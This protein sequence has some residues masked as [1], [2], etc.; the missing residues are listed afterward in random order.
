MKRRVML[1]LLWAACGASTAQLG[2]PGEGAAGAPQIQGDEAK[3]SGE[4]GKTTDDA[5]AATRGTSGDRQRAAASLD[6]L[7]ARLLE[8]KEITFGGELQALPKVP[9]F[10][11]FERSPLLSTVVAQ[12]LRA[13]GVQVAEAREQAAAVLTLSGRVQ[14]EG[15]IGRRYLDIGETFEKIAAQDAE[16]ARIGERSAVFAAAA[17]ARDTAMARAVYEVGLFDKFLRNYFTVGAVADALGIRGRVNTLIAGDPRGFCLTNCEHWKH[18]HHRL[19]LFARL[20]GGEPSWKGH[21]EVKAWMA[22]IDPQPVF[23]VAYE[24]LVAQRLLER[25]K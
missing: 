14:L 17:G 13:R 4:A 10:V 2:V 22:Q 6:E 3:A 5:P 23:D 19:I 9:V 24:T 12:D 18:I 1:L 8:L 20:E 21:V 16:A 25:G 15:S 11:Q 7:K